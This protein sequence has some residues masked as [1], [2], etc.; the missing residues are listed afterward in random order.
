M[1]QTIDLITH[2]AIRELRAFTRRTGQPTHV[3]LMDLEPLR[4][5]NEIEIT[6]EHITV[7]YNQNIE[8]HYNANTITQKEWSYKYNDDAEFVQAIARVIE[9]ARKHVRDLPDNVAC[10]PGCAECCSGYE[11]FVSREDVQR[12]AEHLGLTYRETLD[13]YVV[14]R[15]SADGYVVGYLRKVTDDVADQCVFL[16]GRGSGSY[17]CGIYPARPHDCAAF[18][19]IGCEDVDTNLSRSGSYKVGP[20]FRPRHPKG[21]LSQ[22]RRGRR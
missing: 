18:T 7:T 5:I 16:K 14:Q 1:Q 20:P 9:L 2:A 4:Q 15:T 22:R 6:E 13:R 12:I 3:D 11:P 19:P 8:H 10:P 21:A 17:Y